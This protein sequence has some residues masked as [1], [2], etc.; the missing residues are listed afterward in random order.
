MLKYLTSRS[1]RARFWRREGSV[2]DVNLVAL[3]Q[4]ME[5]EDVGQRQQKGSA[6]RYCSCG[7]AYL[8]RVQRGGDR[9]ARRKRQRANRE[10]LRDD[11][12]VSRILA[13]SLSSIQGG[14]DSRN[15]ETTGELQILQQISVPSVEEKAGNL[16]NSA[17]PVYV[18]VSPHSHRTEKAEKSV[19]NEKKGDA[20]NGA[21]TPEMVNKS[22]RKIADGLLLVVPTKIYGKSVRT[23][24][25]SGATRCFVTPSCVARV[26][27]KGVPQDV[28]LELGNGQ[29]YLS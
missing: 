23:L 22:K 14:S 27:L 1:D 6:V 28:F 2:L 3:R 15:P 25:D 21:A 9:E 4:A 10:R 5:E 7:A 12:T 19:K 24:I 8:S 26:G 29:K 13:Q 17:N 11:W 18:G 16:A 20:G